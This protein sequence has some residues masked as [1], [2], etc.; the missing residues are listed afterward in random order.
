LRVEGEKT[1]GGT[2]VFASILRLASNFAQASMDRSEDR[3]KLPASQLLP[4]SPRLRWTSRRDKSARQA[5]APRRN[6]RKIRLSQAL[7]HQPFRNGRIVTLPPSRWGRTAGLPQFHRPRA[8]RNGR[9]SGRKHHCIHFPFNSGGAAESVSK[10][11]LVGGA[12]YTSPHFQR[13][14]R[15]Q[16]LV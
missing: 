13:H 1:T 11:F 8:E 12:S 16:G 3:R 14:S 7:N 9:Q 5:G 6:K 15:S 4:T 10:Q 2:S